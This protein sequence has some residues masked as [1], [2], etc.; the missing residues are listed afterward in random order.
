MPHVLPLPGS[1]E[2]RI[3]YRLDATSVINSGESPMKEILHQAGLLKTGEIFE[4]HTP[5][6]PAPIID[7]LK[8][9]DHKIHT[10]VHN[11]LILTYIGK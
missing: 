4:L 2:S 6:V 7:M 10:I 11:D 5:F 3:S 8:L 1:D 9:K